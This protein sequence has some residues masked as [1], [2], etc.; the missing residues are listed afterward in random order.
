MTTPPTFQSF[1]TARGA[2]VFAIPVEA[3]PS[4]YTYAY[5]VQVGDWLV[6]IDSGS[7]SDRSHEGLLAGLARAGREL[8]RP[9]SFADL[10]HILIT[11]GHIDHFG[12]L[13]RLRDQIAAQIGIHELDYQTVAHHEAR[14]TLMSRRLAWF[15]TQ[16]GVD[17]TARADLLRL[18]R[19]TKVLYRSINVDFTYEAAGMAVGPFQL[20]HVPGHCPGHVAIRL[21]DVIFCGDLV[22]DHVTPHQS[23][24]ELTPF[25]GLRH[26]F[27]SLSLFRRWA[28]GVRHVWSGHGPIPDV[29][30]RI[31][32]IRSA[33]EQRLLQTLEAFEQPNTIAAACR[34]VYG[35]ANG[36]NALLMIEKMGAYVEY[37]YQ[38]GWLEIVNSNDIERD[39]EFSSN[40][41]EDIPIVR[42]RRSSKS[43]TNLLPE[44]RAYVFL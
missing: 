30:A 13:T 4:F 44:E 1:Q 28:E 8:G 40:F 15:L 24:E 36:Y 10:T 9:I 6:L 14:L 38:H 29:S 23:P 39:E 11:H 12:G 32:E 37:L 22:V 42:Y 7:G 34:Q 17:A 18:Y 21:D 16:A 27:A 31:N 25:L 33:L 3:F 43:R 35:E 41:Q 5:L 19:F 2:K 20:L 26:Y